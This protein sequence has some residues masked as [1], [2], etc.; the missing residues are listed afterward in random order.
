MSS[1]CATKSGFVVI[2]SAKMQP[3]DL[4]NGNCDDEKRGREREK[5]F[6]VNKLLCVC[7]PFGYEEK[8]PL[9]N[10]E[11]ANDS[12]I[13]YTNYADKRREGKWGKVT[14]VTKTQRDRKEKNIM[15]W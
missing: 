6:P 8:K 7:F 3:T 2:N 1:A 13:S 4:K 11:K 9:K 12:E 15:T 10:S 5:K 14:K